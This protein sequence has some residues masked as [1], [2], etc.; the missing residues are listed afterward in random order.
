ME[1]LNSPSPRSS[2]CYDKPVWTLPS[3]ARALRRLPGQLG[4]VIPTVVDQ[5]ITSR[6]REIIMLA[7]SAENR[8]WYCQT[9]HSVFGRASGLSDDEV[10]ALLGGDDSAFAED[11]QA[12]IAFARDLARRS[13]QSRSDALYQALQERFSSAECEAIEA[14]AHVMNFA[15][16]FG[17][18]FDAARSRLTQR[19]DCTGASGLDVAIV[20]SLFV[21]AALA[22]S[23]WVGALMV[24]QRFGWA[25]GGKR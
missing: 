4:R 8:C 7:V 1:P 12:A 17:N 2:G 5:P 6:F 23:P 21:P 15:N 13:F 11:E 25:S 19:G 10:Q 18:T 20:S 16:R 22:V 3:L 9:A 14:T 24:A